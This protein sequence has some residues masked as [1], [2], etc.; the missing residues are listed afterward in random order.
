MPEYYALRRFCPYQGVIQVVDV[1]TARAYSTDGRHWQVR[2]QNARSTF[3]RTGR[4]TETAVHEA[5]ADELM[6]ALNHRPALPFPL[7]DRIELWL[8]RKDNARPLALLKTRRSRREIEPVTDTVWRPFL[9]RGAGFRSD[10]VL[11]RGAEHDSLSER[12]SQDVLERQVNLASR[13]LP[14]AQWFERRSDGSALA[15]GGLRVEQQDE[16]REVAADWFPEMLVDEQWPDEHEA[17]L[18]RDYHHWNAAL[19]L[20]HQNISR[21]TRGR[22]EQAAARN[23]ERLLDNHNMFPEVLSPEALQVALVSAKLIRA[24]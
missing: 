24:G 22:L 12:R 11:R 3:E 6:D 4:V 15:L 20:A 5:N 23:P 17:K 21:A 10:A 9:S 14:V 19:L 18:V 1:G 16:G 13:P 7:A 2:I 8:L